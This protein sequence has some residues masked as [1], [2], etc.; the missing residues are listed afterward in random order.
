VGPEHPRSSLVAGGPGEQGATY[1]V[2]LSTAGKESTVRYEAVEVEPPSRLV[3]RG[4]TDALVS[5]DT[6]EV[7]QGADGVRVTY[8]AELELKGVRKLADP[9]ASLALTRASDKAKDGLQRRLS[10]PG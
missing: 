10:S 5:T 1:D 8:R 9:L 4:E 3:M 6:I 7:E 2:V